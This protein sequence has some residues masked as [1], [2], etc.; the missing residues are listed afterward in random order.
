MLYQFDRP[1]VADA[2]ETSNVL[3]V[4]PTPWAQV[5]D[6]TAPAWRARVAA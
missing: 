5:L 1:F 3:G 4:R 6:A 2:S